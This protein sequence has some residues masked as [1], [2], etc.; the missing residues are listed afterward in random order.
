MLKIYDPV[1]LRQLQRVGLDA[2][3]DHL[4]N[5]AHANSELDPIER[6]AFATG[7][8]RMPLTTI[9]GDTTYAWVDSEMATY[10]VRHFD[11]HGINLHTLANYAQATEPK[12]SSFHHE[13]IEQDLEAG[14]HEHIAVMARVFQATMNGVR[15]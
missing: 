3:R 13:D 2:Y 1:H 6:L 9:G 10:A 12:L 5:W 7:S 4:D 11:E 14:K 8:R 15:R